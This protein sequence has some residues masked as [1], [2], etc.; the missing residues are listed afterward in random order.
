MTS[1]SLLSSIY[2]VHSRKNA[3]ALVWLPLKIT[4]SL[5]LNLVPGPWLLGS[6]P[7]LP[8]PPPPPGMLKGCPVPPNHLGLGSSPGGPPPLQTVDSPP[9]VVRVCIGLVVVCVVMTVVMGGSLE[10]AVWLL[11]LVRMGI[12][13]ASF[14]SCLSLFSSSSVGILMSMLSGWPMLLLS[15]MSLWSESLL[16]IG[17]HSLQSVTSESGMLRLYS[18]GGS[19]CDSQQL[20]WLLYLTKNQKQC[21]KSNSIGK[22]PPL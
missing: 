8:P 19:L 22:Y 14:S 9:S 17:P 10:V 21:V 15:S 3:L 6:P 11:N 13:S 4:G 12:N 16:L 1:V 5:P 18:L 2:M 7:P 20:F